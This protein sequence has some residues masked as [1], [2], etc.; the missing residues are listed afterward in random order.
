MIS[1]VVTSNIMGTLIVLSKALK[2]T[3]IPGYSK[4]SLILLI[5]TISKLT[6]SSKLMLTISFI[7]FNKL[8]VFNSK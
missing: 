6:L 2:E 5:E 8:S 1:P 7:I 4:C 3:L